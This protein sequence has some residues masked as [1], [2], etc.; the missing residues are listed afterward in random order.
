MGWQNPEDYA[1]LEK[2][3]P[4][5]WAW[6]FLRRNGAYQ[7]AWARYQEAESEQ[8]RHPGSQALIQQLH[9]TFAA[10]RDFGLLRF[11]DPECSALREFRYGG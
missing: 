8:R 10:A 3:T 4:H 11:G 5:K 1:Y 2:L 7:E 9:E 6:E